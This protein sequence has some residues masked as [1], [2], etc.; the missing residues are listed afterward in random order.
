MKRLLLLAAALCACSKPAKAPGPSVDM[1]AV[2]RQVVEMPIHCGQ[3]KMSARDRE[4]LVCVERSQAGRHAVGEILV[5]DGG[6]DEGKSQSIA[7]AQAWLSLGF[8]AYVA[9]DP[10]GATES[11]N[12]G[13]EELGDDYGPREWLD[14]TGTELQRVE[15][16]IS[17]LTQ[18]KEP[19]ELF[20][21]YAQ[22][23]LSILGTTTG[24]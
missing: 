22:E 5:R 23:L 8:L 9:D 10:I 24:R 19:P 15:Q 16:G 21:E 2:A 1:L 4:Q 20:P 12:H 6:G 13:L 14:H 3:G 17:G 7:A 11:A 18:R